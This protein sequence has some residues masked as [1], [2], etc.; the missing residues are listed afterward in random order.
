[1]REH[2][3][4]PRLLLNELALLRDL[5]AGRAFA[6]AEGWSRDRDPVCGM[7]I[8]GNGVTWAVGEAQYVFCSE[9]CRALFSEDPARYTRR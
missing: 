3:L 2:F 7:V 8:E 5:A 9:R 1:V 6:R 4:L